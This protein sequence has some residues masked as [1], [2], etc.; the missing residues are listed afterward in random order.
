MLDGSRTSKNWTHP[1][2]APS[3]A[4]LG[5]T[6]KKSLAKART[7]PLVGASSFSHER[8]TFS[9]PSRS[10]DSGVEMS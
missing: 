7:L 2:T 4:Q 6:L 9:E 3:A 10:G 1:V 5:M 8:F